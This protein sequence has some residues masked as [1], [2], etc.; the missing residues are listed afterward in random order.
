MAVCVA[1]GFLSF[2]TINSVPSRRHR[3]RRRSHLMLALV[4][5]LGPF[6]GSADGK[7]AET[8]ID[9][10][11]SR[12]P[13]IALS[14]HRSSRWERLST[15]PSLQ[16]DVQGGALFRGQGTDNPSEP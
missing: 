6:G 9:T 10:L 5:H 1:I 3:A 2:Q 4:T 14:T 11:H 7:F 8:V 12:S 16:G 13:L 15:R